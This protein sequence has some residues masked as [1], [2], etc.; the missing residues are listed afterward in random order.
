MSQN[1]ADLARSSA[2]IPSA[3]HTKIPTLKHRGW[4]TLPTLLP[5]E[6]QQWYPL[7]AWRR[8]EKTKT[9][10]RATRPNSGPALPTNM[11]ASVKKFP[12]QHTKRGV[13]LKSLVQN[14]LAALSLKSPDTTKLVRICRDE[15]R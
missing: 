11:R 7:F 1:E 2:S 14:R 15:K 10:A 9:S 8:Q 3:V 13:R 6:V 12:G 4:G 5:N